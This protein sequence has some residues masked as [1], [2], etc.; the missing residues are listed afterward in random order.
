M[1]SL[2]LGM[3]SLIQSR[4]F[5]VNQYFP[6]RESTSPPTEL[7]TPSA[8]VS[9]LPARTAERDESGHRLRYHVTHSYMATKNP[10]PATSTNSAFGMITPRRKPAPSAGIREPDL[11]DIVLRGAPLYGYQNLTSGECFPAKISGVRR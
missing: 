9:A 8:Q 10:A 3:S 1:L 5:S 7:R 4:A 11:G 2:S 6:V